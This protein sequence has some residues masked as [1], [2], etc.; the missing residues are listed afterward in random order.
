M[1]KARAFAN[2]AAKIV[3]NQPVSRLKQQLDDLI[4]QAEKQ[5]SQNPSDESKYLL[6]QAKKFRNLAYTA[7]TDGRFK[8]AQEYYRIAFYFADKSINLIERNSGNAESQIAEI[9]SN[10]DQMFLQIEE[11]INQNQD[12][13]IKNL[14]SEARKHYADALQLLENGSINLA[15][16][17]LRLIEKLLFR[18]IDQMDRSSFENEDK[19]RNELY[20][21]KAL[22]DALERDAE[23]NGNTRVEKFLQQA[24]IL[25]SEASQAFDAGRIELVKSKLNLSQRFASKAL[26][27]M[28]SDQFSDLQDIES[29]INNNNN[30]LLLQK[31]Q[32]EES[33]NAVLVRMAQEAERL[34][35][36]ASELN[37]Q[38]SI[39]A[40]F[41]N[42][43]LSTRLINKIQR[44][45][46][47]G[48]TDE[49]MQVNEIQE[50]L[51]RAQSLLNK[52]QMN[53]QLDAENIEDI[54]K[55]KEIY[56]T[57]RNYFND[58]EYELAD[59]YV[60]FILQQLDKQLM[61]WSNKTK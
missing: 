9:K 41:R 61:E 48:G 56:N 19:I 40:A 29:K 59:E 2:Q 49:N 10:I 51:N 37:S 42:V 25:Y 24:K 53:S 14:I 23:E 28:K 50:K 46:D 52:L 55:L 33:G 35:N 3:L 32:I 5:Q 12:N 57:A 22:I 8:K 30:L 7:M 20:S 17:K 16:N 36:R 34:N 26:Q 45:L 58:K 21:V 6:N 13:Q 31:P 1:V 47:Y 60:N 15:K 4:N 18:I 54:E 27:F 44:Q 38:N 43:Q 11:M 39:R